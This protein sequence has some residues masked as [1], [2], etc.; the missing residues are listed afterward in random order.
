[1]RRVVFVAP[2]LAA[3]VSGCASL[4]DPG[5]DVPASAASGTIA[6]FSTLKTLDGG[7]WAP[8][9]FHPTKPPT[10]YRSVSMDGTRVVEARADRSVSGLRHRV[11]ID[12]LEL[13]ILEWRWRVD[14][15]I[16]GADVADR[17]ADDSPVRV[18]LAFEGDVS[19]LP[20]GDQ[21][22]IERARL[23]TGQNLPYAT[24]MY[25]WCNR[26]PPE[27]VISNAH[28]SR[29]RKIVVQSGSAGEQR[30]IDY[31]RDIVADFERAY[32]K[33]PGRLIAV[34]VMSDS[35][36]TKQR[37]LGWYGDIQLRAR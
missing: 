16:A 7:P 27:S 3:L 20:V 35:D 5:R 34:G 32:G 28:T 19:T 12:P 37:V 6:P 31:R 18:I 11:D 25:V 13:P 24:L 36:N 21:M 10:L 23:I 9:R 8:W 30:W 33:K 29:V 17:Y 14:G 22:F 4:G 1:M 2:L 26:N 15:V